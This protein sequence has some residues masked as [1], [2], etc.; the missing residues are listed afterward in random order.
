M[1]IALTFFKRVVTLPL[2]MDQAH[3]PIIAEV[4]GTC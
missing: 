1:V 3:S 2:P 4:Y